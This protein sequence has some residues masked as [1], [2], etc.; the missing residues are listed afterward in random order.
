MRARFY[1]RP[2]TVTCIG[3]I[4]TW[5]LWTSREWNKLTIRN[6][7][8]P[9]WL[10]IR[11]KSQTSFV[12]CRK[13][14]CLQKKVKTG[15]FLSD[16]MDGCWWLWWC[17]EHK[18]HLNRNNIPQSKKNALDLFPKTMPAHAGTI[19]IQFRTAMFLFGEDKTK[20]HQCCSSKSNQCR[21]KIEK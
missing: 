20:T 1:F 15:I 4:L 17:L 7:W 16:N 12:L 19:S 6:L 9:C 8:L 11:S 10:R 5:K 13:S 2:S 21:E 18:S 3:P 14:D